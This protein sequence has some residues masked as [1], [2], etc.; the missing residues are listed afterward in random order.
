M[1]R[2]VF[3]ITSFLLFSLAFIN[4]YALYAIFLESYLNTTSQILDGEETFFKARNFETSFVFSALEGKSKLLEWY[5]YWKPVYGYYDELRGCV[6]VNESF[7]EFIDEI[8]RFYNETIFIEA[9]KQKS[10]CIAKEINYKGFKTTGMIRS[11]L[12]INV[13]SP[14]S[15]C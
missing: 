7:E 2:G 5:N 11:P 10:S 13:S 3:A 14:L 6:Q 9:Y 8:M 15:S 4:L 12:C 1:R